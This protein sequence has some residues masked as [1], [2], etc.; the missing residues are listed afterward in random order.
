MFSVIACI[1]CI[2]AILAIAQ[3][4]SGMQRDR[5]CKSATRLKSGLIHVGL[6]V[7]AFDLAYAIW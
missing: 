4:R 5:G 2:L 7:W 3:I 6:Y 1:A